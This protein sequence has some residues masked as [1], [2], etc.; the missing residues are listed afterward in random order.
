MSFSQSARLLVF[1]QLRHNQGEL[2]SLCVESFSVPALSHVPKRPE[3]KS[4]PS[5][6]TGVPED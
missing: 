4:L 3:L 5:A 6:S 2:T 1:H